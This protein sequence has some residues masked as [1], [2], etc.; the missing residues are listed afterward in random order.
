MAEDDTIGELKILIAAQTGTRSDKIILKKWYIVYKDHIKLCDFSN[1]I[2]YEIFLKWNNKLFYFL[3]LV[4]INIT[5]PYMGNRLDT[6][7]SDGLKDQA[8]GTANELYKYIDLQGGGELVSLVKEGIKTNSFDEL[9]SHIYIK[10]LPFLENQ[11]KGRFINVND[12]ISIRTNNAAYLKKSK[13]IHIDLMDGDYVNNKKYRYVVWRID[14][15]GAVGETALHVCLLN[16][17][18]I[19]SVLA[20]HLLIVFPNL[21]ND[22][23]ISDEYY[24][25]NALHMA[26]VNEE[27]DMVKFLLS[28]GAD[29]EEQA[30]GKFFLPLD[31]NINRKNIFDQE[32]YE[33]PLKTDYKGGAN[34][35]AQDINGNTILHIMVIQENIEMLDL[36]I[37]KGAKTDIK[38]KVG[39][40]P[41]S[42][43]MELGK[44]DIY[45]H[46]LVKKRVICWMYGNVTC[47]A[48]EIGEID[49]IGYDG[50]INQNSSIYRMVMG[51]SMEQLKMIEGVIKQLLTEKWKTFVKQRFFKRLILFI[52]YF[53]C[54]CTAFY[55]RPTFINI[56]YT[57]QSNST[58]VPLN[59]CYLL[60]TNTTENIIRLTLEAVVVLGTII[61]VGMLLRSIR[62][63]GFVIFKNSMVLAPSQFMFHISNIF[64]IVAIP[65]RAACIYYVEDELVI[66]AMLTV[67]P[68]FLFFCR[69][70]RILGPFV[71]MIYRMIKTDLF[72]F[73]V[74]YCIFCVG[75][76]QAL[77]INFRNH[78]S[79]S[80]S[81]VQNS[82][83]ATYVL[84]LGEFGDI[85]PQF[86]AN[87]WSAIPKVLFILYMILV[88]LVL[89]NLLIAMMA[90][91]YL[92]VSQSDKEWIRQWASIILIIEQS[93]SDLNRK[94]NQ[95]I[96][97]TP[98]DSNKRGLVM[99]WYQSNTEQ[100]IL[101]Q[102]KLKNFQSHKVMIQ[103]KKYSIVSVGSKGNV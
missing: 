9:Q 62:N 56:N 27:I 71:I 69:G 98:M 81:T 91:T 73:F 22:I 16:A 100:E 63:Q 25:E 68:Y 5:N 40:T 15:R 26:I 88:T 102:E 78:D 99:R 34:L 43:A 97:T 94:R 3:L 79:G 84:S 64:I 90:N 59:E 50:E 54:F 66:F 92:I 4:F 12:L 60:D 67:A 11:G 14:K 70:F 58:S 37:F 72:R 10:L 6:M 42:M 33:L 24:G 101:R 76:S 28:M 77:Y 41:L 96:Y 65:F 2:V 39:L 93:I 95:I 29:I 32:E 49:T 61:Y 19:H 86:E 83:L 52:M 44:V 36:F 23:Y 17:T 38:N 103:T 8:A 80:F 55:L 82:V 57:L 74:I 87:R 45:L 30:C 47:A 1:K 18:A 31:Q 13:D 51:D 21:I 35:N 89:I 48:Y 75:F 85:Y 46:L 53:I 20:K 7:V